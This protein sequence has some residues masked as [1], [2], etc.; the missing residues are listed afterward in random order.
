M[1][2]ATDRSEHG[3]HS[4]LPAEDTTVSSSDGEIRDWRN[5]YGSLPA[6]EWKALLDSTDRRDRIMS[7]MWLSSTGVAGNMA[8]VQSMLLMERDFRVQMCL[9]FKVVAWRDSQICLKILRDSS[10]HPYVLFAILQCMRYQRRAAPL[11]VFTQLLQA[12]SPF[13]LLAVLDYFAAMAII[14][15]AWQNTVSKIRLNLSSNDFKMDDQ[16]PSQI[17]G[18]RR[19]FMRKLRRIEKKLTKQSC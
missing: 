14:Y 6:D 3:C 12:D 19:R 16:S 8:A 10:T 11:E 17:F 13:V 7:A 18:D 4:S 5:R 9:A 1:G 2:F 15:P